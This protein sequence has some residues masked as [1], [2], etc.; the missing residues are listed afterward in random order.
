MTMKKQYTKPQMEAIELKGR[1]QLL[2]GSGEADQW[3][4]PGFGFDDENELVW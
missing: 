2:A 1:A 3:G 4:A